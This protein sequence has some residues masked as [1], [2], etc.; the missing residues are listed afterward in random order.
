MFSVTSSLNKG[1]IQ[2]YDPKRMNNKRC[3]R[4][5]MEKEND[6]RGGKDLD[7]SSKIFYNQSP[8]LSVASQENCFDTFDGKTCK[9]KQRN[10]CIL[11]IVRHEN[12]IRGA[13]I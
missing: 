7:Y 8:L 9:G 5:L 2:D 10:S 1:K 3:I 6:R 4:Q 12:L 11:P 13:G